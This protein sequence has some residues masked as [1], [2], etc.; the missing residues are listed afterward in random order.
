VNDQ[1]ATD[2]RVWATTGV[3]LTDRV[4]TYT[5]GDPTI[6]TVSPSGVVYGVK[7]GSTYLR[8]TSEGVSDVTE[9]VVESAEVDTIILRPVDPRVMVGQYVQFTPEFYNAAGTL[10]PPKPVTWGTSQYL[11]GYGMNNE[12]LF[13]GRE[14]GSSRITATYEPPVGD[15]IVGSSLMTVVSQ[16]PSIAELLVSPNP[17]DLNVGQGSALRVIPLDA[18]R[19]QMYG[20]PAPTFRSDNTSVASVSASGYVTARGAGSTRVYAIINGFEGYTTVNVSGS[21]GSSGGGGSGGG[22]TGGG[23]GEGGGGTVCSSTTSIPAPGPGQTTDW[24]RLSYPSNLE[25]R[26]RAGTF[27]HGTAAAPQYT[28]FLNYRNGYSETLFFTIGWRLNETATTAS[29]AEEVAAGAI[30]SRDAFSG[31]SGTISL[32]VTGARLGSFSAPGFCQ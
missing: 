5:T 27:N 12:G 24:Y 6:A 9:I 31:P 16:P 15:P 1:A 29:I 18:N 2:V 19:V 11:V 23:G 22:G 21:G 25:V 26:I 8:A 20:L 7:V 10:L 30:E 3:S 14:A 32:Y 13:Y 17:L 28:Y 4:V